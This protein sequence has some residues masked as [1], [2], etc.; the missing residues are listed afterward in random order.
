MLIFA[1]TVTTLIA[2]LVFIVAVGLVTQK[3]TYSGRAARKAQLNERYQQRLDPVLLE[4]LP[5][6]SLDPHSLAFRQSVKRLCEPLRHDLARINWFSRRSHRASL[7]RVML[8]MSRELVGET[9]ARLTLAFQVFGF[10][11]DEMKDLRSRKW[12]IRA[13][14]ARNLALMRAEDATGDLVLLVGDE[15]DDVRTEAAMALVTISGVNAL[16]P[17]L[18]N[19]HEIS[20]WM[21]IRLSKVVISM[22]SAAVPALVE[23]LTAGNPGIKGFAVDLLGEIGDIRACTPLVEFTS[24][25][26]RRLCAKALVAIGKLGDES[27]KETLL[28]Y[29]SSPDEVLRVQA[30]MGLGYLSSPETATAL[31]D[32]L[33]HDTIQVRLASGRALKR[34]EGAGK[35]LFETAY[36]EAD[37]IG[38]R[39]VL[40]FLE[41]LGATE[42]EMRRV[43]K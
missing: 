36:R 1:L 26:D 32:H 16:G 39:V 2:I 12:W 3:V 43:T 5:Q 29:L 37:D 33:L 11:E 6:E 30:A 24:R 42:D 34:I 40:Q 8:G 7:Q 27:G 9:L 31:K 18:T 22:G 10:V 23:A 41:E 25:A 14:A 35:A 13:K 20:V 19:L 38:K 17:L 4:D 28:D 15:E 21:S